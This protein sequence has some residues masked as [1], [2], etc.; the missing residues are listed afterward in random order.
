MKKEFQISNLLHNN[1]S[2]K[3]GNMSTRIFTFLLIFILANASAAFAQEAPPEVGNSSVLEAKG[4]PFREG[5]NYFRLGFNDC[6]VENVLNELQADGGGALKVNEVYVRELLKW[7]PY[8]FSNPKSKE[9][10]VGDNQTL[11]F[12][13]NQ[14]FYLEMNQKTCLNPDKDREE[15]IKVVR[16][17]RTQTSFVEKVRDLPADLWSKLTDLLNR[18]DSSLPQSTTQNKQTFENLT[19]GGKTTVS[20]LGVTGKVTAGLLVINGFNTVF[21]SLNTLSDDLY[22]QN[23][24]VGG[25]N[26]LNGKVLV[27][28]N[29]NLEVTKLNFN[30][31][32]PTT[33]SVGSA[34]MTSGSV[35]L[36]I[37]TSA[38][39]Q[40]S[41]IFLTPTS[42]TGGQV[43]IVKSKTAGRGFKVIIE[44]SQPSNV[45]FDW[46]IIN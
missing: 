40:N 27:D 29:G 14:K 1:H 5:W 33:S 4:A 2:L 32:D 9:K 41:K 16:E 38:V 26:I 46:L 3:I 10:K 15:Q 19:I 6:T 43:L 37:S 23:E 22:I 45:T 13:S 7:E 36:D 20:D 34:T 35:S 25:V 42:E 17:G 39:T 24:G 8:S 30:I 11:A 18:N 28:K 31:S 12:L 21:A 44:K